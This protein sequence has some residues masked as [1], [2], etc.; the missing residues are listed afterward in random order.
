MGKGAIA[1]A[2]TMLAA[3]EH[4]QRLQALDYFLAAYEAEHGEISEEE[5]HQASRRAR[6]RARA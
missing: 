3:I 4:D 5:M 2:A 6:E 1:R